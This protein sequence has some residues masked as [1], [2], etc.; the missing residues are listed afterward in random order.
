MFSTSRGT[1]PMNPKSPH[2]MQH[3]HFSHAKLHW[4]HA[5][6]F[7]S[8]FFILRFGIHNSL[9]PLVCPSWRDAPTFLSLEFHG[10]RFCFSFDTFRAQGVNSRLPRVFISEFTSDA[11]T[12]TTSKSQDKLFVR[13]MAA[14]RTTDTPKESEAGGVEFPYASPV[15]AAPPMF[16]R[17]IRS[18]ST[19]SSSSSGVVQQKNKW[20]TELFACFCD[21]VHCLLAYLVPLVNAACA[22][23]A[24]GCSWLLVGSIFFLLFLGDVVCSFLSTLQDN[25][26][27]LYYYLT[28]QYGTAYDH[29]DGDEWSRYEIAAMSCSLAFVLC[30]AVLRHSMRKFYNLEGKCYS[31]FCSS[32]WFSCCALAQMSSHAQKMKQEVR[33]A[34]RLTRN[35]DALPSYQTV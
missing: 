7:V 11:S 30:V 18:L 14:S 16:P 4:R 8:T 12:P 19:S 26:N 25:S 31:D 5:S 23:D 3:P 13:Q 33:A 27:Y 10:Q 21:P 34:A 24:I 2:R 32:F 1:D 28:Y 35:V 20:E 17:V 22:A 29:H 9:F 15:D 6:A